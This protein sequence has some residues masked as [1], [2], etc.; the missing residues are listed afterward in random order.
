[1][2][3]I[4]FPQKIKRISFIRQNR[5]VT[6]PIKRLSNGIYKNEKYLLGNFITIQMTTIACL[7][8]KAELKTAFKQLHVYI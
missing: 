2:F 4:N 6:P 3:V 1:M 8:M 7:H 5:G